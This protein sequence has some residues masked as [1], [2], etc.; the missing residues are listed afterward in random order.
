MTSPKGI[1]EVHNL[2]CII[3]L[4]HLD[5]HVNIIKANWISKCMKGGGEFVFFFFLNLFIVLKA[6]QPTFLHL[7]AGL[8]T[9]YFANPETGRTHNDRGHPEGGQGCVPLPESVVVIGAALPLRHGH[10]TDQDE[11]R[12]DAEVHTSSSRHCHRRKGEARGNAYRSR[13]NLTRSKTT[14]WDAD[15]A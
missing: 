5:A 3:R 8:V 1:Y 9:L 12:Q 15:R 14:D 6:H 4:L 11:A 7:K 13:N 2:G 10:D